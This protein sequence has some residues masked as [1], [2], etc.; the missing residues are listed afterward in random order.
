VSRGRLSRTSL[1]ERAPDPSSAACISA[2]ALP[3]VPDRSSA[4]KGRARDP[5]PDIDCRCR[6]PSGPGEQRH[7]ADQEGRK[8]SGRVADRRDQTPSQPF[9]R[10]PLDRFT[11]RARPWVVAFDSPLLS[12]SLQPPLK[13][14]PSDQP[15]S[16]HRPPTDVAV[17][18]EAQHDVVTSRP[19]CF[20]GNHAT[21]RLSRMSRTHGGRMADGRQGQDEQRT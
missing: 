4:M 16:P 20:G 9:A 3:S 19:S 11:C 5:L 7:Q 18:A 1:T 21:R 2:T 6:G 15:Q 17:C 8:T 12:D 14:R 10:D 13:R